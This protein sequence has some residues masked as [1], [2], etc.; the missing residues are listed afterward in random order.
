[1]KRGVI[2]FCLENHLSLDSI[3]T[4]LSLIV[5]T[6][7][8]IQIYIIDITYTIYS[9]S[10]Y[11]F[12]IVINFKLLPD[13]RLLCFRNVSQ[14][15]GVFMIFQISLTSLFKLL[16]VYFAKNVLKRKGESIHLLTSVHP[17]QE[18]DL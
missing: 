17:T 2:L 12:N 8:V 7:F 10:N 13:T 3:D 18:P 16:P 1:M 11:N 14:G 15:S 9:W 4:F 6:L 5:M